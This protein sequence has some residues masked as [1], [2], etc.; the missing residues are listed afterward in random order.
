[1]APPLIFIIGG[2]GA[3]G[4][5]VVSALVHDGR[6]AVR[7][8]TRDAQSARSRQLASFSPNV[9]FLEGSFAS[10]QT[11]RAGFAGCRYAFVNID[12]F[13]SGEKTEIYWGMRCYEIAIESGV[14]FFVWAN[15]DYVYKKS[16]YDAKFRTGH[17]DGKGR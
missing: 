6:Y 10:E 17:Y 7:I 3:Q 5:P 16:G 8:L 1:M 14:G 15:L 4:L 9:S 12:G 2:T 11:L 13:N